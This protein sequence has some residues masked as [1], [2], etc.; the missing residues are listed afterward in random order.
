M[1]SSCLD[2]QMTRLDMISLQVLGCLLV[3]GLSQSAPQ[4]DVIRQVLSQ[5]TPVISLTVG[6][7]LGRRQGNVGAGRT[8]NVGQGA[9]RAVQPNVFARRVPAPS[10]GLT[11]SRLTSNVVTSLQPAI[12]AAVAQALRGSQ[13]RPA[14]TGSSGRGA[15]TPS[16]EEEARINAQ[17]SANAQYQFGYKVGNEDTQTY[18]AHEE[19]RNGANVEGKYN[20]VDPTGSLVTVTYQA[21]PGGYT[22]TREVEEGVVQMRNIPGAWTGP[23]AGVS[24]PT[25]PTS[26]SLSSA[27]SRLSQSDLIAQILSAIQPQIIGAVQTA[28]GQ[29]NSASLDSSTSSRGASRFSSTNSQRNSASASARAASRLSLRNSQTASRQGL[30]SQSNLISTII[31]ALQPQ[32]SGAVQSAI[33]RS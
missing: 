28:V 24:S 27:P 22:E 23:L 33:S 26:G 15:L 29:R 6:S 25:S 16:T 5:L 30:N 12:S 19:T 17:Q 9:T 20:Y 21:G 18:M 4:Q 14:A 2:L 13:S 3:V 10:S 32:I 7:V 31:S 1:G 8:T 11:A